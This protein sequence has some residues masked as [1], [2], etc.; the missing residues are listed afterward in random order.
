MSNHNG[1]AFREAWIAGVKRHHPGEPRAGYIAPWAETPEW[2]RQSAAAVYDLVRA[3]IHTSAGATR[4][5]TRE[6]KSQFV[7]LCWTAQVYRH[8]PD[9]KPS[10]VAPWHQLPA[11]Q[12]ETDADIFE[13]IEQAARTS[14]ASAGVQH[15]TVVIMAYWPK[16]SFTRLLPK[17]K[18]RPAP[19]MNASPMIAMADDVRTRDISPLPARDMKMTPSTASRMGAILVA[20]NSTTPFVSICGVGSTASSVGTVATAASLAAEVNCAKSAMIMF[21]PPPGETRSSLT[22]RCRWFQ[23]A[24]TDRSGTGRDPSSITGSNLEPR[25]VAGWAG[26]LNAAAG[27]IRTSHQATMVTSRMSRMMVMLV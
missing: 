23:E 2:E 8:I 27:R 22:H 3:L 13:Q 14:T 10:Y 15:L 6:Q 4:H 19:A 17:K 25:M 20:R 24:G 5:L 26:L 9:P 11:W 18:T 16:T 12:Q 21:E 1:R 7:A